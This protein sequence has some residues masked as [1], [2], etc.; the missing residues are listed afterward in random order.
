M[1][2]GVDGN[3]ANIQNRVG[4]GEYSFEILKNLVKICDEEIVVYLKDKPLN[5]L[6]EKSSKLSYKIFGPSK[7][8][9]QV[10]LPLNLYLRNPKPD[11]FFTPGHYA[12]RF[13]PCPSVITVFDL[14]YTHFPQLFNKSDLYQLKNWT[15][16]SV[17]KAQAVLTIS[18]SSKKDIVKYYKKDPQKVFV[19]YLGYDRNL[20]KPVKDSNKLQKV[21]RKYDIR[22]DYIFFLGTIQPRKNLVKLL[23][24]IKD[25]NVALVISGKKGWLYD[26]FF[27]KIEDPKIKDKVILT[28]YVQDEDLPAL[29]SGAQ[30]FVLSSLWEGFGIPI[31]EAMACGC[32][33]IASDRSSLPEVVGDSGVLVNSEDVEAITDGIQKVL[34]N[35]KFAQELS[36]KGIAQAEKFSWEQCATK[37]LKVLKNTALLNG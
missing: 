23:E 10:G 36:V 1:I 17:K 15:S 7:F 35:K 20:F 16:Y 2:I 32:P 6:P 12:P 18:E 5:D 34:T 28:D 21:R 4:S 31:L 37:T 11:V 3:E 33:V 22:G 14:S 19:T 8:W 9:T 24:A 29:F 13:C 27:S 25:I 26:D 30:A